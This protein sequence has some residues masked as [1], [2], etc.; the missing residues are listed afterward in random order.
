MR[1]HRE[2]VSHFAAR[3]PGAPRARR[4]ELGYLS[5]HAVLEPVPGGLGY[6]TEIQGRTLTQH[7]W[8]RTSELL[9]YK[10][11]DQAEALMVELRR[12]SRDLDE[13]DRRI[14][15]LFRQVWPEV[16]R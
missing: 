15:D 10:K 1:S 11:G 7:A 13:Q 8:A 9:A 14:E 3:V 6:R 5:W 16:D 4:T 2:I 12:L